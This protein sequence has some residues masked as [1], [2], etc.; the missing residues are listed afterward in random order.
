[1]QKRKVFVEDNAKVANGARL[2]DDHRAPLARE[3][4]RRGEHLKL[5]YK[6]AIK[7]YETIF[8]K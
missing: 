4:G 1:L 8:N 5:N 2:V 3:L 7:I 6:K